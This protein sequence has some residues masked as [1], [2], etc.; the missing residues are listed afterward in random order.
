MPGS[1]ETKSY[2]RVSDL[3]RGYVSQDTSLNFEPYWWQRAPLSGVWFMIGYSGCEG[4]ERA[5]TWSR[6]DIDFDAIRHY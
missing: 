2:P 3:A 4:R 5:V 1:P 6:P